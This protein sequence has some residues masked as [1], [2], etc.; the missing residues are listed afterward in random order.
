[1]DVP[2][3]VLVRADVPWCEE[4]SVRP[5]TCRRAVSEPVERYVFEDGVCVWALV[6][7]FEEFLANLSEK[8]EW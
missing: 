8:G 1:V 5:E 4:L 6:R 2:F 7:P 3:R